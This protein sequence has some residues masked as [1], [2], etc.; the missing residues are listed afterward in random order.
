M[1]S[2]QY[3]RRRYSSIRTHDNSW[4]RFVK[5]VDIP[6]IARVTTKTGND[7]LGIII[8][9]GDKN[10]RDLLL[11]HPKKRLS[12]SSKGEWESTGRFAYISPDNIA[13]IFFQHTFKDQSL[14]GDHLA[15]EK[16]ERYKK[17]KGKIFVRGF[18][19]NKKEKTLAFAEIKVHFYGRN[20]VYLGES[21][22]TITDLKPDKRWEFDIPHN[23]EGEEVSSHEIDTQSI[24]YG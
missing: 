7:I 10:E 21:S 9:E 5:E 19:R 18:A 4:Q 6:V 22:E 16:V 13:N 24:I 17:R 2:D 14:G 12:D 23:R 8:H 3:Y 11:K 20:D 15:L 1:I